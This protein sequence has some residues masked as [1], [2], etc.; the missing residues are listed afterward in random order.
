M[1]TSLSWAKG[2][3]GP[4]GPQGIQGPTGAQGTSGAVGC[5]N[6]FVAVPLTER[7]HGGASDGSDPFWSTGRTNCPVGKAILGG[8]HGL[9]RSDGQRLST[10]EWSTLVL[11]GDLLTEDSGTGQYIVTY[12][13]PNDIALTAEVTITCGTK[14]P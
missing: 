8:S 14:V 10:A 1:A 5:T 4:T 11:L 3:T 9:R 12:L 6:T 2:P 13:N 7:T